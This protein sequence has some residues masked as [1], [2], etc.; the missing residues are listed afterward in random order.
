MAAEQKTSLGW[1][2][3]R[4]GSLEEKVVD[5]TDDPPTNAADHALAVKELNKLV[6]DYKALVIAETPETWHKSVKTSAS[7]V[8]ARATVVFEEVDK[9]KT[10][11]KEAK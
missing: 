9:V 5:L 7:A 11:F 10:V 6:S 2:D 8:E 3:Q 1:M 4:V